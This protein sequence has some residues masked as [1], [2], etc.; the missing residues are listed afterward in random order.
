MVVVCEWSLG[1]VSLYRDLVTI[2]GPDFVSLWNVII[3]HIHMITGTL[4]NYVEYHM[5]AVL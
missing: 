3:L 5:T 1:Q 2:Y 4:C